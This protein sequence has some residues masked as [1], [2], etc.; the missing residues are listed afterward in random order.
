MLTLSAKCINRTRPGTLLVTS[1]TQSRRLSTIA[2]LLLLTAISAQVPALHRPSQAE[3]L[4]FERTGQLDDRIEAAR[5]LGNHQIDSV[6]LDR[7]IACTAR[8]ALLDSA[9]TST[10]VERLLPSL[11]LNL[12]PPPAWERLPTTGNPKILA[13]LIEFAE[14]SRRSIITKH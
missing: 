10:D 6:L 4:E 8:R 1:S 2:L 5:Q 11:S 9:A 3:I 12:A 7:A 13:L 14:S